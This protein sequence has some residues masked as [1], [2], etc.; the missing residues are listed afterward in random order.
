MLCG[1]SCL[2]CL[3]DCLLVALLNSNCS[4]VC[5]CLF[6]ICPFPFFVLFLLLLLLVHSIKSSLRRL[7]RDDLCSR[8]ASIWAQNSFTKV[9]D[10]HDTVERMYDQI[11]NNLRIS[12]WSAKSVILLNVCTTKYGIIYESQVDPQ[13]P[14]H[15]WMY[16]WPNMDLLEIYTSVGLAQARPNYELLIK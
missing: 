7:W 1:Q 14:W 10:I 5:A 13:S 6:C 4:G 16:V 15:C 3:S 2:D 11:W 12:S 8:A 9:G